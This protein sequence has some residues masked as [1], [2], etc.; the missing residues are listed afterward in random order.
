M[1]MDSLNYTSSPNVASGILLI[2]DY[3]NR[4]AYT[5]WSIVLLN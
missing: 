1:I 5:D 4:E 2:V 3:S